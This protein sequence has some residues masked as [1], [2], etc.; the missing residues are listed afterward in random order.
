MNESHEEDFQ[1]FD[2]FAYFSF[3]LG[4]KIRVEDYKKYIWRACNTNKELKLKS[5]ASNSYTA[6]TF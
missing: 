6:P 5:Q 1:F 3:I 4:P 2:Y